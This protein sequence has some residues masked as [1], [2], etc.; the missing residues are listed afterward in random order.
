MPGSPPWITLC[1]GLAQSLRVLRGTSWGQSNHN[2][3]NDGE[4]WNVRD[5][6]F[7]TFWH[8]DGGE[9]FANGK[10]YTIHHCSSPFAHD[11]DPKDARLYV[12]MVESS[13]KAVETDREVALFLKWLQEVLESGV[14][15]YLDHNGRP[16]QAPWSEK[17]GHPIAGGFRMSFS[18]WTGD[19]EERLSVG[20][21]LAI[22]HFYVLL[23]D[24]FVYNVPVVT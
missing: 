3:F 4:L 20:A 9:V 18:A 17:S 12:I 22:Q 14:F 24:L 8:S 6:V 13:A 19:M 10:T 11:M 21:I 23:R 2:M 15:P 7:P 1:P 16:I 5:K